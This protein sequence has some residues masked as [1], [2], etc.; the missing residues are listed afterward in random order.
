MSQ[1]LFK[2]GYVP[3]KDLHQDKERM[4][5]ENELNVYSDLSE[6]SDN[7]IL[8]FKADKFTF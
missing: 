1:S 7:E 4:K 2:F 5:S 3:T 8:Q 6:L